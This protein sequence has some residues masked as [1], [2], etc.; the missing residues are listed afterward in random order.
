ME[1]L[2]IV[3]RYGYL[4]SIITLV[5]SVI[6]F[7]IAVSTPPL[8]GPF[9]QA[10]CFEYPYTDIASRFPRDYIWMYPAILLTLFYLVLILFIHQTTKPDKKVFSLISTAFAIMA[11]TVLSI[12]YFLQLSVIQ[13][14]II[15][16]EKD[17]IA[18]LTQFNPHGIFIALE[19]IGFFFM[20]LSFLALVPVF[21]NKSRLEKSIKWT[22]LVGFILTLISFILITLIFGIKREYRFEVAIIS[23]AW[24]ELIILSFLI[25]K[26]FKEMNKSCLVS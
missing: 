25:S 15:A 7:G 23:I 13:P 16:G 22:L 18:L 20:I 19:E 26:Y 21:S 4:V 8:S 14:S 2:K 5:L 1:N 9:C 12:D 11:T 10:N 3:S 17:G 6:T 24:I